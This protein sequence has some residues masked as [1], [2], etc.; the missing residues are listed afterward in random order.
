MFLGISIKY[1]CIYIAIIN[2][3][4]FFIMWYDKHQAKWGKWRVPEKT[5]FIITLLGGSIGTILGMYKFRHK[6]K[7]LYF[8]IGFPTILISEIGLIIYLCVK[9]PNLI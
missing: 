1:I 9:Y 7:K 4:G 2:F 6:T 3:I 5:L 8:T